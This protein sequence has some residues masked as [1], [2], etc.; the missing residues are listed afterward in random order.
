MKF[1]KKSIGAITAGLSLVMALSPVAAFAA[2]GDG[3]TTTTTADITTGVT[4]V[5]QVNPG[6]NVSATFKYTATPT[7]LNANDAAKKTETMADTF[8]PTIHDI[9]LS[10]NGAEATGTAAITY[11]TFDHAGTYAWI[12]KET[13][14]TYKGAGAMQ[15]D[16]ETYTLVAVV[17]NG[18]NGPTVAESYLIKGTATTTSGEKVGTATFTNKYTEKTND[19]G[20]SPLVVKKTVD[21]AQGD[22]TKQFTFT[23]TFTAPD[24]LPVNADG[25][26]Q[27]KADVLNAISATPTDATFTNEAQVAA[28]ATSRSF[29]FTAANAQSV[30]FDNVLVG[31]TYK[32][33]ETESGQAGYTT[34]GEVKTAT[35]LSETGASVTVNNNKEGSPVTGVIVNNAPFIVMAG[36]AVAGVVAYGAAKRKLEN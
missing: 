18:T 22:K 26:Q 33:E 28:D 14:D 24:V 1:G 17:E 8:V 30:T 3:T 29:T 15:Y 12:V 36:A 4:K 34:T 23:V 11:P 31:T 19:E 27:T 16:P 21:G 35:V 13:A 2:D 5:L 9:E 6:S 10:A 20:N 25:A 32:V 7:V